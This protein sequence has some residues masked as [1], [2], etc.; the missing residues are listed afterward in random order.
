[1]IHVARSTE[2]T[3]TPTKITAENDSADLMLGCNKERLE[4]VTARLFGEDLLDRDKI[5][6][7]IY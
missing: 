3:R 6:N 7:C 4:Q 5:W 2:G 1:M